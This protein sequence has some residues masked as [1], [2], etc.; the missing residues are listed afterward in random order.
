LP[1]L[2]VLVGAVHKSIIRCSGAGSGPR[3][4]SSSRPALASEA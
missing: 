2:V 1:G 4:A 3:P